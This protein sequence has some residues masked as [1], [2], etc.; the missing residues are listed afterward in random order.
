ML[1]DLV[2]LI[3]FRDSDGVGSGGL[4]HVDL[5]FSSAIV[6]GHKLGVGTN[7]L[8]LIK[9]R[10][11][12]NPAARDELEHGVDK[13]D[14]ASAHN[15]NGEVAATLHVGITLNGSLKDGDTEESEA[16]KELDSDKDGK[17]DPG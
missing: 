13:E 2:I 10:H 6:H 12:G 5:L 14:A 11:L 8:A 9:L 7:G 3:F 16:G 4:L 15:S 1:R 17:N